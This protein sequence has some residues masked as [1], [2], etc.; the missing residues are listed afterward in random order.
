MPTPIDGSTIS[1]NSEVKARVC[2]IGTG[3][4]GVTA[5]WKLAS[6]GVTDVI[7]IEGS[8]PVQDYKNGYQDSWPDKVKLYDGKADEQ[9]AINN[10]SNFLIRPYTGNTDPSERERVFG[11]TSAH[12]GGQ[13]RPLDP[14]TFQK[15]TGFP[16]WPINR[17]DLDPYYN[18]AN[19][20][21]GLYG[22]YGEHGDNFT[23][24][25]WAKELNAEIPQLQRFKAEMYQF[26]QGDLLNFATRTFD[27][28]GSQKTISDIVQI[29]LNTSLLEIEHQQG[30]AQRLKVASM[31]GASG[32]PQQDTEFY[33]NADI[34]ILA[35]G[36][37]ANARQMLLSNIGNEWGQVGKYFSCH[38]FS[39]HFQTTAV[40]TYLPPAQQQFMGW[41]SLPQLGINAASARMVPTCESALTYNIGRSWYYEGSS[42]CYFEMTPNPCSRITLA[43]TLDDVFKQPQTHI[44]WELGPN[45][46]RTYSVGGQLF[47]SAVSQLGH[48][49][50]IAPWDQVK[51]HLV[52][53]GHHIGT[54]R[55]SEDPAQGVVDKNL[56]VH[57]VDNFYVAGSSVYPTTGITNPTFTIIALSIRLAEH[58]QRQ[59][60]SC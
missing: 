43:D 53:N 46:E 15:R 32:S 38:P 52:V 1:D 21:C 11:G 50:T 59:L 60:G 45:D 19:T 17:S 34:Y 14:I 8:R 28:N 9:F 51:P 25:F 36:A 57:T 27:I 56:K 48:S 44:N 37:V 58:V 54:T 30:S 5:A 33:I 12:W 6:L 40:G 18:Q 35:C 22:D 49:A 26:M 7:M 55:M 4:A 3:Q 20:L 47:S 39:N 42:S 24:E 23:N 10:E 31:K 29:Y 13:S 16:G 41:H 2:I